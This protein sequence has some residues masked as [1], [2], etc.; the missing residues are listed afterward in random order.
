MEN[1]VVFPAPGD[2]PI[3]CDE[4]PLII[5]RTDSVNGAQKRRQNITVIMSEGQKSFGG[6]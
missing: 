1:R 5:S 3:N 6:Q 2:N 4:I